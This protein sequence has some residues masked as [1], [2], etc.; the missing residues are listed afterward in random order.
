MVGIKDVAKKAGVSISTVS[1]VIN[2]NK[3]VSQELRE[4]VEKAID[5]LDYRPHLIARSLKSRKTSIIGVVLNDGTSPFFGP[6]LQGI[7]EVAYREGF[8]LMLCDSK[9][10]E[11]REEE[12]IQLLEYNWVDGIILDTIVNPKKNSSYFEYLE[13]RIIGHRNIPLISIVH[14]FSNLNGKNSVTVDNTKGGYLATKHLIDLGHTNIVHIIGNADYMVSWKRLEGYTNALEEY[15][16]PLRDNFILQGNFS[17][18]SGYNE[19]KKMLLKDRSFTAI[20]ASNDQMAIGAIKAMK[21]E[22][23]RIPEDVAIIGFDNIH[24]SS[25]IDPSLSTINVPKY[26]IGSTAME[27]LT[28]QLKGNNHTPVNK[29]LP[30]NLIVRRSSSLSGNY[31]WDLFGI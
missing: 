27:I 17:A 6:I 5:E 31:E 23:I 18:L 21:E 7:E 20:F 22:G 19:I 12:Y 9:H 8:S 28:S 11:K 15:N 1:S 26:Q 13:K 29:T 10:D 24:L 2:N 4:K 3:P 16:I 14:E 25:I 30:I